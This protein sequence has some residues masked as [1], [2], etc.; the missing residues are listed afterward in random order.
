FFGLRVIGEDAAVPGRQVEFPVEPAAA[1]RLAGLTQLGRRVA[2]DH[3]HQLDIRC[4][5]R[6][7]AAADSHE[8]RLPWVSNEPPS[9]NWPCGVPLTSAN[10]STGPTPGGNGGSPQGTGPAGACALGAP[11]DPQVMKRIA[12]NTVPKLWTRIRGRHMVF[13][14]LGCRNLSDS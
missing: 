3:R 12:I 9:R 1:L 5:I 13:S 2:V 6:D 10:F 7:P 14:S 4:K 11:P 8:H